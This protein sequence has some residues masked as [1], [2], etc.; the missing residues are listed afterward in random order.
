MVVGEVTIISRA[1]QFTNAFSHISSFHSFQLELNEILR[2]RSKL[3]KFYFFL[4]SQSL[5]I[6]VHTSLRYFVLPVVR[7]LGHCEPKCTSELVCSVLLCYTGE[8]SQK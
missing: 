7:T 6:L 2:E 5:E 1:L 8:M 3:Q 4:D